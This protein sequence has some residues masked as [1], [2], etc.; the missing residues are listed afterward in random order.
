M[1]KEPIHVGQPRLLAGEEGRAAG[2]YHILGRWRTLKLITVAAV[3]LVAL[4]ALISGLIQKGLWLRQLG[5]SGVFWTLL[6]L[7]WELFCVAFVIGLLYLWI[8]LRLAARNTATFRAGHLTSE[9]AVAATLGIQISPTVLKLATAAVAGVAALVL[10]LVFY[11]Q[12]DTYLRF[13]YGGSL[14]D[15]LFGVDVAFY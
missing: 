4:L 15:P 10:A 14:S 8:N 3:L 9:S 6:S 7:R 5:Y 1:I 12:W 2:S 11:A 13:R